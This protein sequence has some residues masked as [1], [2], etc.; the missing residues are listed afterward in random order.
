MKHNPK[1][2][3]GKTK[4]EYSLEE[5]L[6]I[7][8]KVIP[9]L[10]FQKL[11]STGFIT[12]SDAMELARELRRNFGGVSTRWEGL[13]QHWL[14]EHYTGTT[15]FRVE[16]MLT[17]LVAQR[18]TDYKGIDWSEI[19]NQH[20]DFAGHN[21]ASIRLLFRS[22]LKAARKQKKTEAVRKINIR[23]PLI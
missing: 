19:V 16:V 17:K 5:D 9:R 23:V 14:L 11:S 7:L 8:E 20:K 18:Y 3:Q 2:L 13:V 12:Q 21:R 15:G 10:K 22:C 4:R 1:K 6:L